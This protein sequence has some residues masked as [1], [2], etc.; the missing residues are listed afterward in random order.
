MKWKM[1]KVFSK[2]HMSY[3]C[4]FGELK[5]W[6][7]GYINLTILISLLR[8]KVYGLPLNEHLKP[9]VQEM[10][11]G[12]TDEIGHTH[13]EPIAIKVHPRKGKKKKHP[14][15]EFLFKFDMDHIQFKNDVDARVRFLDTL[16]RL[17]FLAWGTKGKGLGVRN[18]VSRLKE[19]EVRYKE[20]EA[21]KW[22]KKN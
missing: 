14:N 13:K 16:A 22:E 9:R 15:H 20:I 18:K 21:K 5:W 4:G 2:E 8:N 3:D 7:I 17:E 11:V 12:T 1:A 10:I 6:T 19:G